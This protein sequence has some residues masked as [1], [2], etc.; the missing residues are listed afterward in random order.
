[1]ISKFPNYAKA[2]RLAKALGLKVINANDTNDFG[3][4]KNGEDVI[5]LNSEG[6]IRLLCTCRNCGD[7]SNVNLDNIITFV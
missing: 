2:K 3:G 1:M 4:T 5:T 7:G 6:R